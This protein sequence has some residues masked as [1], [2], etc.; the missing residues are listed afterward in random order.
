MF[1]AELSDDLMRMS[2]HFMYAPKTREYIRHAKQ[3][4]KVR[5]PRR[6]IKI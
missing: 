5:F 2:A 4:T 1:N 3:G 6:R